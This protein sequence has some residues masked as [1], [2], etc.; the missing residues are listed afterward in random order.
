M[1]VRGGVI[2]KWS[3][4]LRECNSARGAR[5]EYFRSGKSGAHH[6]CLRSTGG[7]GLVGTRLVKQL[8]GRGDRV[9]L[10]QL[11]RQTAEQITV[12]FP[13]AGGRARRSDEGGA[14]AGFRRRLRR[15]HPSRRRKHLRAPLERRRPKKMLLDSRTG[16]H[17]QRRRRGEVR[18]LGAGRRCAESAG[19]RLRHRHLRPDRR[20]GTGREQHDW[21]RFS[22]HGLYP[23]WE[24]AAYAAENAGVRIGHRAASASCWTRKVERWRRC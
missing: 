14:V 10:P 11:T 24:K 15:R 12:R 19:Q 4:S 5:V 22:S 7:T 18:K 1:R 13:G 23:Q 9:V 17:A 3:T 21:P 6:A 8:L 20:R 16:E 2:S